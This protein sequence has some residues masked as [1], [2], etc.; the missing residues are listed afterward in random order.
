MSTKNDTQ[1]IT[2]TKNLWCR[3]AYV[4]FIKRKLG[5]NPFKEGRGCH[6]RECTLGTNCRGA[7]SA[8]EIRLLPHI[9]NWEK[10]DKSTYNFPE[11]YEEILSIINQQ[12]YTLKDTSEFKSRLE[13]VNELNFIELIQLWRELACHYRKIAKEIPRKRDWQSPE[14][15]KTH[16]SGYVFSNDVPGFYLTE[17]V[18]D[19]MWAFERMTRICKT[20]TA[21]I[22]RINKRDSTITIWDVCCGDKNCKE[23]FHHNNEHICFDDFLN[24][25]CDCISKEKYDTDKK[26][27]EDDIADI[28]NKLAENTLKSKRREQLISVLENKQIQ[29]ENF[30]RKIHYTEDSNKSKGMK[31]FYIQYAEHLLKKKEDEEKKKE[32]EENKEKPSWDHSLAK[33]E[34]KVIK[35]SLK[36]K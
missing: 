2:N 13:K 19:N 14:P 4:S 5:R 15:P 23:G 28:K 3:D 20:R 16:S 32:E 22:N 9:F 25:K 12:K 34:G 30:D 17:K 27:L 35:I 8:D 36:K 10:T 26:Q 7:H 18:E 11:V 1:E 24:G 6:I 31:P 29:L 33:K 21:F